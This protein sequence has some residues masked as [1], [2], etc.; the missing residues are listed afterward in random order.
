MSHLFCE[1]CGNLLT[2][3]SVITAFC[4]GTCPFQKSATDLSHVQIRSESLPGDW[5]VRYGIEPLR[6]AADQQTQA[7]RKRAK[8][9]QSCPNCNH[10]EL[11]YYTMQ[12]RSA[13]EG[14]TVFYECLKCGHRYSQNN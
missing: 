14:A 12:L 3:D 2:Y 1:Q 5:L 11:E 6:A 4:C 8:V 9:A 13:D 10:H 7:K